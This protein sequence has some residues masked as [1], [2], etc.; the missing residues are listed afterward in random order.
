[1]L[2]TNADG[3]RKWEIEVGNGFQVKGDTKERE[4]DK[5]EKKGKNCCEKGKRT[6]LCCTVTFL[7]DFPGRLSKSRKAKGRAALHFIP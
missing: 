1:M 5:V 6:H 3:L 2:V 4:G 7:Y